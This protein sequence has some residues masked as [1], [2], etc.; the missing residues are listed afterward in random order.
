M[1]SIGDLLSLGLTDATHGNVLIVGDGNFSFARAFMRKNAASLASQQLN[2][3]A[4]SLDTHAELLQMYPNA[5]TILEELHAGGVKVIHDIN[6]TRLES[7]DVVTSVAPFDRI[8]FNFPHFAEGGSRRNKIHR[9]RQL[10]RDFFASA[11]HVLHPQ[12]QVWVTLCAGQGGTPADTKQRAWGDTWQIV[13]C[14]ADARLL[15]E[16]VHLCPVE[17]L[18]TLGYYSVGYQL[19]ERAFWTSDSLSHVFCRQ[20]SGRRAQFPIEWNRDMS[21]WITDNF[22][23]ATFLDMVKP[24]FPADRMTLSAHKLDDYHCTKTQRNA[25][26]YRLH[27]T[28]DVLALSKDDVNDRAIRALATVEASSF[29]SSRAS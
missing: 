26:T 10:L 19:R 17:E 1:S 12:G 6:A 11:V 25:V 28:S 23:E 27:I 7:Y 2:V 9:H 8:L 14:A 20:D 4:T 29:A 18:A 15:L 16:N 22:D 24:F 5:G 13:H 21:F 3:M